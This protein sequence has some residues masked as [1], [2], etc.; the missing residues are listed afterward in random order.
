MKYLSAKELSERWNIS[1]RRIIKLCKENRI[2]GAIKNGMAWLIPEDSKKPSDKR[3]K[4]AQ[5]IKTQKKVILMNADTNLGAYLL[6]L[7]KKEGYLVTSICVQ[8]SKKENRISAIETVA[9]EE[10]E[11]N[12]IEKIIENTE[13][14]YDGLIYLEKEDGIEEKEKLIIELSK[15]MNCESS[16]VLVQE[17]ELEEKLEK[18]LCDKLKQEIGLR[19]NALKIKLPTQ[20]NVWVNYEEIAEDIISLFTRFKNT[21]GECLTTDGGHLLF[22]KQGRTKPLEVGMF[23]KVIQHYFDSLTKESYLWSASTMLEDEWTE[24]PAEM[25][26]RV[27][28]LEAANRGAKIDR[29][30]I[31]PKSKVKEFKNNK[32]L[33]IYMQSNI[34]TFFVDYDEILEKEPNLFK[35]LGNGWDGI[36]QDTLIVDLP[37]TQK[38][39][40]RGY[41][42]IQKE[43][44]IKAYECFLKLKSYAKDLKQILK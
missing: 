35:I 29:I 23:Y 26:F 39:E 44:V 24:E 43:E 12:K 13:K 3:S 7:L 28:N 30:F 34:H 5:Y 11:K 4:I 42:T 37:A 36:D 10:K 41:V 17:K 31:F 6:P 1:E 32:T 19:I 21:T 9:V 8:N 38:N 25:N 20:G 22:D 16:I 18:K 15:K 33:Q 40:V 27:T 2:A 14:Y